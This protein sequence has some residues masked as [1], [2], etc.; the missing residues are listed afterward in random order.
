MGKGLAMRVGAP[1]PKLNPIEKMRQRA[2]RK[3]A[4]ESSSAN[5]DAMSVSTVTTLDNDSVVS[6]ESG[7][8]SVTTSSGKAPKTTNVRKLIFGMPQRGGVR[9]VTAPA[10]K[11]GTNAWGNMPKPDAIPISKQ[12]DP[13]TIEQ[14]AAAAWRTQKGKPSSAIHHDAA[15]TVLKAN[16]EVRY[17]NEGEFPGLPTRDKAH[18]RRT[19]TDVWSER[20]QKLTVQEEEL[21]EAKPRNRRKQVLLHYG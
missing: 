10:K 2:E 1:K 16:A 17:A 11:P 18:R 7:L 13:P 21:S 12:L 9:P 3:R 19:E 8:G 15:A 4:R 5:E 6:L 14:D 20:I